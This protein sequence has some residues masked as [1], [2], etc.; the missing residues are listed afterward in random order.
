MKDES[1]KRERETLEREKGAFAVCPCFVPV[2]VIER[3]KCLGSR[4]PDRLFIDERGPRHPTSTSCS[5]A[6]RYH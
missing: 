1:E 3:R 6:E 4:E 2:Q 5:S